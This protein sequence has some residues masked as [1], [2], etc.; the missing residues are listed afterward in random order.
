[1][2]QLIVNIR[3]KLDRIYWPDV[4]GWSVV[5]FVIFALNYWRGN[6]WVEG[7]YIGFIILMCV[8]YFIFEK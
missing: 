4:I 3:E 1:M 6:N 7:I 5:I 8:G 2:K